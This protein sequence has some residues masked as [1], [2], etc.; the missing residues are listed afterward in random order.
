MPM[1]NIQTIV[2]PEKETC[3]LTKTDKIDKKFLTY[4][5]YCFVSDKIKALT[6]ITVL[7]LHININTNCKWKHLLAPDLQMQ[8]SKTV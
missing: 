6:N 7:K 4:I 1:T 8:G 3:Y 2:W 5:N